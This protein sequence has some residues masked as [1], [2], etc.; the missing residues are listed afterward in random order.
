MDHRLVALLLLATMAT[1]LFTTGQSVNNATTTDTSSP[2]STWCD[3]GGL[4][5]PSC[6]IARA[7]MLDDVDVEF[8][9]DSEISRR[10][11]AGANPGLTRISL[12]RGQ[13]AS[14]DRKGF[15]P[16]HPKSNRNPP[17]PRCDRTRYNRQ[18]YRN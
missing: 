1:T 15:R 14:C 11:L 17:P 12:N 2:S 4:N 9:M 6:L 5:D 16:C 3:D 10:I 18:C 13:A 8:M 7:G